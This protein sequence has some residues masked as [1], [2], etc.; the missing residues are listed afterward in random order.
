MATIF[1]DVQYTQVMGHLPIPV[2]DRFQFQVIPN[3]AKNNSSR[4]LQA[5]D[6]EKPKGAV[7]E[8]LHLAFGCWMDLLEKLPDVSFRLVALNYPLVI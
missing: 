7:P 4:S 1:G 8:A 5:S 6:K 3:D 2:R